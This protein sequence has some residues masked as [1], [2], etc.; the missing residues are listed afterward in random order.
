LH[1]PTLRPTADD[2]ETALVKTSDLVQQCVN[3]TCSQK[4]FPFDNSVRPVCPFCKTPFKGVLPILNLYYKQGTAFKQDNHRVM[5]YNGVRLYSWHVNR[6]IFPN[7]KLT[8]E[9]K[10]PAAYFQ[11]HNGQWYLVNETLQGMK[12]IT[13]NK[14]SVAPG[15]AVQLTDGR[16]I[17]LSDEE[18]GRLIQ[19]QLVKC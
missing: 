3:P 7:E 18:G 6:R 2:W 19:V 16:Q 5:V 13:D 9:Q 14:K 11:F 10:K 15:V 8:P 4:W 1:N 12:D 17:L